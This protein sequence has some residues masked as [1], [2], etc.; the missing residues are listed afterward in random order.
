MNRFMPHIR[1]LTIIVCSFLFAVGSARYLIFAATR[2]NGIFT[3]FLIGVLLL[4]LAFAI[5][6]K[7]TWAL[8]TVAAVCLLVVII[9]PIGLFNPFTAGDYITSG[10]EPPSIPQTLLWLVPLEALLVSI[11]FIIDPRKKKT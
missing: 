10:K 7:Y 3:N 1:R 9:L 8:R 6:L 11:V 5:Y 2:D 4:G